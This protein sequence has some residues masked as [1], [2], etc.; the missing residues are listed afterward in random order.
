MD[1]EHPLALDARRPYGT[2]CVV[3]SMSRPRRRPVNAGS[4][5]IRLQMRHEFS[6]GLM[7]TVGLFNGR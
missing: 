1:T 6:G 3:A 2:G 7:F 4:I 5:A